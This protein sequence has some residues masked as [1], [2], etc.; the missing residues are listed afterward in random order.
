LK[1]AEGDARRL[2]AERAAWADALA[3]LIQ[4]TVT[5]GRGNTTLAID[6]LQTAETALRQCHV[7]HHA[8]AAQYRRG[9]LIGGDEG[10]AL[11]E[12]ASAWMQDQKI[13]NPARMA[14][15]LAPGSW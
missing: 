15:L 2:G 1:R 7:H 14:D 9:G 12:A 13:V 8:A 3:L 6:Q 11:A 4:A 10:R 5:Q